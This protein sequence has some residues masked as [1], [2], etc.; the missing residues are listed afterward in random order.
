MIGQHVAH[1]EWTRD[2][3]QDHQVGVEAPLAVVLGP[4][5]DPERVR[6]ARVSAV[7]HSPV[8]RGSRLGI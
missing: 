2:D 7:N 8:H 3:P 4:G 5:L 6:S 1:R